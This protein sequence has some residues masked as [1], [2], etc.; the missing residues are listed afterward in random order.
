MAFND[1][2][3][4]MFLNTPVVVR[5]AG[6]AGEIVNAAHPSIFTVTGGDI[7][8]SIWGKITTAFGANATT[9]QLRND[10]VVLG[11]ACTTLSGQTADVFLCPTGLVGAAM[12]I[13]G[14]GVG[15]LQ[16]S[17]LLLLTPGDID[18]LVGGASD[19]NAVIDWYI[20]YVPVLPGVGSVVAA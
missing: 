11:L 9:L 4:R 18:V 3:D 15:P 6:V 13:S 10:T 16:S 8:C 17:C 5:R 14:V 12:I 2:V 20:S 1:K 19:A 7:I